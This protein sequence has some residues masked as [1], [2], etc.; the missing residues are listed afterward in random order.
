MMLAT[1]IAGCMLLA[2]LLSYFVDYER[3]VD[4]GIEQQAQ[5]T[6]PNTSQAERTV[7]VLPFKY[8]G[9]D[10]ADDYLAQALS[11]IVRRYGGGR[12]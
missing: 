1:I 11:E 8:L 12:R 3:V 10:Q 6:V 7:A 9:P 5:P 2:G 4:A